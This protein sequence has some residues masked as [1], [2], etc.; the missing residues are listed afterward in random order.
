A[1]VQI[2]TMPLTTNGKLD[3]TSLPA[4][5]LHIKQTDGRG[6]RNQKE[7]ILCHLFEEELDLPKISTDDR[8]FD[9]VWHSFLTV[10]LLSRIRDA[11]GFK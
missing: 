10:P 3:Q 7:E 6:P 9:I 11:L 1:Y 4:P 5:Q 8:F 2:A